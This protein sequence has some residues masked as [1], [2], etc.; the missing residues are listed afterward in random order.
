MVVCEPLVRVR[1]V[2]VHRCVR[3][4][5]AAVEVRLLARGVVGAAVA[6]GGGMFVVGHS[7]ARSLAELDSYVTRDS[8]YFI[9]EQ[10]MHRSVLSIGS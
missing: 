1:N 9:L 6:E 8:T 10:V 4:A 2:D 5:E 7:T 3:Q